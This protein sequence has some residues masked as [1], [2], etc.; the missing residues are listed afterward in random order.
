MLHEHIFQVTKT[1]YTTCIYLRISMR[2]TQRKVLVIR[3]QNSTNEKS[4]ELGSKCGVHSEY[5]KSLVFSST[6]QEYIK[7]KKKNLEN[8][9]RTLQEPVSL[10]FVKSYKFSETISIRRLVKC[11]YSQDC[12]ANDWIDYTYGMF[13]EYSVT[14]TTVL[15]R[16]VLKS[17]Q[18][19]KWEFY[20]F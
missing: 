1:A 13:Y 6:R 5:A 4:D 8:Y 12:S 15:L 2:W 9:L 10:V 18:N 7:K 17:H 14:P 20:E 16:H 19:R 11:D 3:I